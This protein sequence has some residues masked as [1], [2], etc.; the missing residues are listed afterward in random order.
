M[1]NYFEDMTFVGQWQT[2][3]LVSRVGSVETGVVIQL[4]VQLIDDVIDDV[5]YKVYGNRHAISAMAFVAHGL[6]G[7][8]VSEAK[9]LDQQDIVEALSIPEI[10][11]YCAVMASEAVTALAA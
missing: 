5:R 4:Q 7:K 1:I 10:Y 11:R 2:C 9:M 3:S 8:T 6:I